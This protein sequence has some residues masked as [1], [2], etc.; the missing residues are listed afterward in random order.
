MLHVWDHAGASAAA[1]CLAQADHLSQPAPLV[2]ELRLRLAQ[3]SGPRLLVDGLW[4]TRAQGGISRVWSQILRSWRLPGLLS[5]SAPLALI[6]RNSHTAL[7]DGFELLDGSEVDPLDW[8]S[9]SACSSENR[10]HATSWQAD[11]FL[12]SWITASSPPGTASC[13]P[14]L[15][16]VHDCMPERSQTSPEQLLQRRRWLQGAKAWLAVSA[17]SASDVEG[18][19]RLQ[20]GSVPWCHPSVDPLFQSDISQTASKRLSMQFRRRIGLVDPFVL[21]PSVSMPGSYKNPELVAEALAATGLEHLVFL[22]SGL[23]CEPVRDQMLE[24]FPYLEGRY[25]SASLTDLELVIAYREALAVVMPSRIEGFGLPAVEA[26]AA[27][28]RVLLA[29]SRGLREAGGGACL[30][31]SANSSSELSALLRLLLEPST[32]HWLD[33]YLNR[34]RLLHLQHFQP[35]LL[36]LALLA[37]ARRVS[38]IGVDQNSG[39][40][41]QSALL[42]P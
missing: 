23:P 34:R 38:R 6:D 31:F 14:E 8:Q 29:D 4:L 30:R 9:L 35:H 16:L 7:V 21:M 15:A 37:E 42:H 1:Q 11:V 2:D 22:S 28:G 39:R 33:H 12:S 41:S 40:T 25:L 26:L 36:G 20:P 18:L 10:D 5:S 24:Q 17:A 3:S 27:G 19:L 13:C 32:D